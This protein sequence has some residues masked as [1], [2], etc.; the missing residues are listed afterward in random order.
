MAAAAAV[1]VLKYETVL[2]FLVFDMAIW[3]ASS[4]ALCCAVSYPVS[5]ETLAVHEILV[6]TQP[7]LKWHVILV[8]IF[9][10][11]IHHLLPMTNVCMHGCMDVIW[12]WR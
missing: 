10:E 11:K 8:N 12:W 5:D 4:R 9:E 1:V 3:R 7:Q 6:H 2:R